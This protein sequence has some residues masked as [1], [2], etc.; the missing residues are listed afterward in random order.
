MYIE[1]GSAGHEWPAV[2]QLLDDA[3]SLERD[4]NAVVVWSFSWLSRNVQRFIALRRTL[5][6]AGVRLVSVTE[7]TRETNL[8]EMLRGLGVEPEDFY[9]A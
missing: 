5:S 9:I 6:D 3:A 7:P 8:G 1:T 4:F 2:A